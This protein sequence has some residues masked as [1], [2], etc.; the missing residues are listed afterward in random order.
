MGGR[1]LMRGAAVLFAALLCIFSVSCRAEK[2]T[3]PLLVLSQMLSYERDC[4]AGVIYHTGAGEG[5]A[6][7]FSDSLCAA[8]YGDGEAP[9]EWASVAEFAIF[10]S[11]AATPTELA[12]F[13][14]SSRAEAKEVAEM[15]TRRLWVLRRFYA[16]S[17]YEAY[18]FGGSVTVFGKYVVSVVSSDVETAVDEARAALR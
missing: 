11:T 7:Y 6:G 14:T 13:R 4:P 1:S 17:E 18:A 5:E 3:P 9:P 2:K 16:G 12:V 8:F 10:Q 15:C